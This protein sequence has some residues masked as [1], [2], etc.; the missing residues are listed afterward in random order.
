LGFRWVVN[1]AGKLKSR[2][3]TVETAKSVKMAERLLSP[4]DSVQRLMDADSALEDKYTL[5]PEVVDLDTT[6]EISDEDSLEEGEIWDD[7]DEDVQFIEEVILVPSNSE[8]DLESEPD[9]EQSSVESDEESEEP[10]D[11][12]EED[13]GND[14][15]HSGSHFD[16]DDES[17]NPDNDYRKLL[18][19][20]QTVT[21]FDH[22]VNICYD[23]SS[24]V[25]VLSADVR[26]PA[27]VEDVKE[28]RNNPAGGRP[29]PTGILPFVTVPLPL[30]G[31]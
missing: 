26:I 23:S 9:T 12:Y 4:S 8:W 16:S 1:S 14:S 30:E 27:I 13:S 19:L 7:S 20:G 11:S 6:I 15:A 10:Y 25:S 22:Q 29:L 28:T 17:I 2:S 18:T 21:L 5:K 31:G 24:T 3:D